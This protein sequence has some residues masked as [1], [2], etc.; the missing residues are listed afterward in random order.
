MMNYSKTAN[1]TIGSHEPFQA[2]VDFYVSPQALVNDP[3][4]DKCAAFASP[5]NISAGAVPVAIVDEL[6]NSVGDLNYHPS[7]KIQVTTWS[8]NAYEVT[9]EEYDLAKSLV[10]LTGPIGQ[11]NKDSDD[12]ITAAVAFSAQASTENTIYTSAQKSR[13]H[14]NM[15][16]LVTPV[17]ASAA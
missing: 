15:Y 8:N 6:E 7:I 5:A 13:K 14:V 12:K 11:R 2:T 4:T 9:G 17:T 1:V 16:N 3:K 10:T